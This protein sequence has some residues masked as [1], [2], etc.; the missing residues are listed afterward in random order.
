MLRRLKIE[1][2]QE[3]NRQLERQ[4][5]ETLDVRRDAI[6]E[7]HKSDDLVRDLSRLAKK[8]EIEKKMV[9]NA[10]DRELDQAKVFSLLRYALKK[11]RYLIF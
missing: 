8:A 2:L 4:I 1:F 7:K 10:A 11:K 3:K 6:N 5:H 9:A